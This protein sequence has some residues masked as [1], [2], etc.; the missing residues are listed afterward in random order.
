MFCVCSCVKDPIIPYQPAPNDG[1]N[2]CFILNEGLLGT[3]NASITKYN[4]SDNSSVNYYFRNSNPN[5]KLGDNANNIMIWDS[6]VFVSVSGTG[7][8]E[9]FN[10]ND[11]LSQGRITFPKYMMPRK[12]VCVNDSLAFVSAYIEFSN[13]EHY[14]YYFNPFDLSAS[15]GVLE[16]NKIRVGSH[17]EGI[18][19]DSINRRIYVVNCGYG[20]YDYD[21]PT[22]STISI[23]DV[24]TKSE[25]RKV[26]TETNPNRIYFN[27]DKVY[28]ISWGLPSDTVDVNGSII[29]YEPATMNILRRW[30]TNVYDICFNKGQDTLYFINSTWSSTNATQGVYFIGL[31]KDD[32]EPKLI[33]QNLNKYDMW[34]AIQVNFA[35][36]SLWVANSFK[37]NSDG[38]VMIYDG[39]N[40]R[41]KFAVG[42]IPNNIR[43]V[44]KNK[45]DYD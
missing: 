38:E 34:T 28:V 1:Y 42:N 20:D 4:L 45:V 30:K 10:I 12:M 24:D 9:A 11:G 14:V 17:P 25:I 31:N 35:D 21:N 39:S 16:N 36:N 13:T 33:I 5:L 26:K 3:D 40:M 23:I 8:V 18:C 15:Q 32:S 6:M 2:C 22:A 7:V 44:Y 43:F 29:E 19:Y 27:N 41:N 37:Y